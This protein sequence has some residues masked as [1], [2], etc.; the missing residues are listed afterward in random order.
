MMPL[1]LLLLKQWN[2]LVSNLT[3]E[4]ACFVSTNAPLNS[5]KDSNASLKV[6]TTKKKSWGML[7]SLQ[8]FEGKRGLLEPWDGD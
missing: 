4:L 6:T 3:L 2:V 8:H 7:L 1:H 5:L